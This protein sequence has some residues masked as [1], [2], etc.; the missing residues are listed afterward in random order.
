MWVVSAWL[1]RFYWWSW[2]KLFE[3]YQNLFEFVEKEHQP[4]AVYCKMVEHERWAKYFG[5]SNTIKRFKNWWRLHSFT[6]TLWLFILIWN[7]FVLDAATNQ[8]ERET[9]LVESVSSLKLV[10]NLKHLSCKQ[11]HTIVKGD[12]TF[13]GNLRNRKNIHGLNRLSKQGF[14]FVCFEWNIVYTGRYTSMLKT[15]Q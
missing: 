3:Q 4:N 12:S 2:S 5:T 10:G 1:K 13:L 14:W 7:D 8:K 6:S 9:F 11:F 15:N